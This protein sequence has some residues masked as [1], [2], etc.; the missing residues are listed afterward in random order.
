[1]RVEGTRG[2]WDSR[3][4]R[5]LGLLFCFATAF[6]FAVGGAPPIGKF[7]PDSIVRRFVEFPMGSPVTLPLSLLFHLEERTAARVGWVGYFALSTTIVAANRRGLARG[8]FVLLLLAL[9]LNVLG[10][11]LVEGL[12]GLI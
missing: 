4:A 7:T 5:A 8:C 12:R 11:W 6:V 10:W 1:V 9:A 2:F 3:W